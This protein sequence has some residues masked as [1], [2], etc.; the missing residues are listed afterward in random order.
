[1]KIWS[2]TP[3]GCFI[4]SQ[5]GRLT[6]GRTDSDSEERISQPKELIN[7]LASHCGREELVVQEEME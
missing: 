3:D 4:P 5:T 1:M 7:Q 6:I 2:K